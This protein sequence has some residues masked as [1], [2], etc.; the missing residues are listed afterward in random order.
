MM[1]EDQVSKDL[2][3]N[4]TILQQ[5]SVSKA[6]TIPPWAGYPGWTICWAMA[7]I[8]VTAQPSC[9]NIWMME[10]LPEAMPPTKHTRN[11]FP[12]ERE[13][14]QTRSQEAMDNR[15][16]HQSATLHLGT[17]VLALGSQSWSLKPLHSLLAGSLL[18]RL[19]FLFPWAP[20][21]HVAHRQTFRQ[22][23]IHRNTKPNFSASYFIHSWK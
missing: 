1:V 11:I 8:P 13:D 10:L 14:W 15:H 22:V 2:V 21:M 12:E 16:T 9:W 18:P 7:S 23:S 5:D 6:S 3:V 4:V 19:M 20:S 17:K